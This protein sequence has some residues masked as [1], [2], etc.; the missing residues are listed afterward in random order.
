MK[1][2]FLDLKSINLQ[3]RDEFHSVLDE[4]LSSG[5][6]ILGEQVEAFENEF[7]DYCG[8]VHCVGVGNG[9][10]ALWLVLRA[11]G[12]GPGDEV[13]VPSNTFIA[14]WLAVSQVGATPVSVEP[15]IATF[16]IDP[17]RIEKAITA[18]T[19]AII[20][21]HL[22]GQPAEMDAIMEIADRHGLKV[23]ED[24][25]QS[26]GAR[27]RGRR[28][29]GLGHA[30]G[31][32]FYPS[33]NL[34]ALGDGGAITTHDSTLAERLRMLRNY[35]ARTKYRNE[36]KGV[37]SRLDEFQA[38]ILRRKLPHLDESNA[39]RCAVAGKYFEGL[40]HPGIEL[41]HVPAWMSP[42]WHLYVVKLDQ[43][44]QVRERLE[45]RGVEAMIHYPV[46]PHMQNAYRELDCIGAEE[47]IAAQ[48]SE[49]VLSLPM[50]PHLTDSQID[51]VIQACREVL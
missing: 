47:G 8:V 32:S 4:V 1:I 19:R 36:E 35:G 12:V 9:F 40:Q 5:K 23:L 29:G 25:A 42:V 37:N 34:G 10:D 39:R 16:N 21:V 27:Y 18:R 26:H 2:P 51:S 50:G 11:W 48:L 46:P 30:A 43:R 14:T 15:D 33:K 17:D 38:A 45:A 22:Y 6:T 44:N 49:R 13:I 41:P 28:T 31:F 3:F 20:P 24:A 7:A